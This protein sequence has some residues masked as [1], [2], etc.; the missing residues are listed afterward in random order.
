MIEIIDN[1]FNEKDIDAFYGEFRDFSS[2]RFAGGVGDKNWR[3]FGIILNQE[4]N[5]HSKLFNKSNEIFQEKFPNYAL[6]HTL[7]E[8]YASGYVYGTHHE[9]HS[10]YLKESQGV[11]IMFYLNKIWHVSYAGETIFVDSF[12]EITHSIIPKPGRVAIFDGSIPHAARE[13]SRTCVEL[14]MVATFKYG[15]K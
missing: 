12:G 11:T 14:R 1:V 10:D 15:R 3:K 6:T 4:D 8:N 7:K 5:L 2:W 9:I 13:V